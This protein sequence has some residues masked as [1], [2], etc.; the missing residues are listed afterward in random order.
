MRHHDSRRIAHTEASAM[1]RAA[2]I[3]ILVVTVAAQQ[4]SREEYRAA[5]RAWRETDP[6]LERESSGGGA[7]IAQ[8]ADRLA[9]EAAK[10]SAAR[11][12]FLRAQSENSRQ[13]LL[14]LDTP[15]DVDPAQPKADQE[16]VA[17]E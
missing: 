17:A 8:R 11:K 2:M 1:K 14:W 16:I 9:G 6:N 12:E 3:A 15:Q 4:R 7:S 13:S 10:Y 5:Y